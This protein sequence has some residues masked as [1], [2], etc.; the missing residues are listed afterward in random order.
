[1]KGWLRDAAFGLAALL[2]SGM[3]SAVGSAQQRTAAPAPPKAKAPKDPAAAWPDEATLAERKKTAEGRALFSSDTP[4]EFTLTAD[5]KMVNKD[6]NP[7]S[8]KVFP[9][10]LTVAKADGSQATFPLNIRTRGHVRRM[11]QTCT[12]APLR[13]EFQTDQIKGTVFEGHKNIKLGT[14]CRDAD[15]FEQYVPRE[16]AAYKI[17]NLLT[18]R[19]FR[20]RMGKA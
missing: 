9:A 13:L 6:R 15:L 11:T 4:L 7:N 18:P 16:Y 19:S 5:F 10:T 20:A 2:L 1:M 14:H 8:T 17:Y 3:L 12:F